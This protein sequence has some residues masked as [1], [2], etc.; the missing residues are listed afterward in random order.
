MHRGGPI[1]S[2]PWLAAELVLMFG[3]APAAVALLFAL[4]VWPFEGVAL[5]A[6]SD[7]SGRQWPQWDLVLLYVWAALLF[8]ALLLDRRFDKRNLWRASGLRAKNLPP[9]VASWALAA[10]VLM[11]AMGLRF[12]WEH[13]FWLGRAFG[14]GA[15]AFLFYYGLLLVYPQEIIFRAFFFRRYEPLLRSP[16]AL[17]A[18]SSAAFGWMHII[19]LNATA[20]VLT[21]LG[22]ALMGITYHR[23]R[24]MLAVTVEHAVLGW[25]T[26]I[27]GFGPN[28]YL[29]VSMTGDFRPP[30]VREM[31]NEGQPEGGPT[32]G[33]DDSPPANDRP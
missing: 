9:M 28:F 17:I 5:G 19:Y 4:G 27:V 20:I 1:N 29:P 32:D 22:G 12:G 16:L 11:V 14:L 23:T 3:V 8:V 26:F 18:A 24:S 25:F 7:A 13:V 6:P 33:D 30:A 2:K 15:F 31:F 10:I 21:L